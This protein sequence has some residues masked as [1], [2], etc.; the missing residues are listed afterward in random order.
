ML[1]AVQSQLIV[2]QFDTFTPEHIFITI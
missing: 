1:T 2:T